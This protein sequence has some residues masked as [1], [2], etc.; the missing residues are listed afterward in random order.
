MSPLRHCVQCSLRPRHAR[1]YAT[2][3]PVQPSSSSAFH[4]F[5][6]RTKML[7]RDRAASGKEVPLSRLSDY[8]RDE[9]AAA[10]VERLLVHLSGFPLLQQPPAG[11][12]SPVRPI[13]SVATDDVSLSTTSCFVIDLT[14]Y[15]APISPYRRSWL[16]SGTSDK[17]P[18]DGHHAKGHYGR[19]VRYDT[20]TC[21]S[22]FSYS[23]GIPADFS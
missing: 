13:T 17:K 21:T 12:L 2:L 4:A 16:W 6:R 9:V 5:D 1:T 3:P 18:R 7:Q 22:F 20:Q 15:K 23:S 8:V 19:L 11:F 14:G 10:L